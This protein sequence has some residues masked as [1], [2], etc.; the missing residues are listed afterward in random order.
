MGALEVLD[1]AAPLHVIAPISQ[2]AEVSER[3]QMVWSCFDNESS[4]RRISIHLAS[5]TTTIN[6]CLTEPDHGFT[7]SEKAQ[8]RFSWSAVNPAQWRWT[9]PS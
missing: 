4:I 9:N 3:I 5:D 6:Y 7:A 2:V 1:Q 8:H